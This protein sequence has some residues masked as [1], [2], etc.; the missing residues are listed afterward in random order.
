MWLSIDKRIFK[1]GSVGLEI[2]PY[3]LHKLPNFSSL[4]VYNISIPR[5]KKY[6][7][8]SRARSTF[9]VKYKTN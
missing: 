8:K 2:T 9:D 4:R 7:N 5:Y 6:L 3:N 1:I